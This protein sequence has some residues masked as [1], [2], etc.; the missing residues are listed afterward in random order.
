MN[1]VE[2]NRINV[3][4]IN[5]SNILNVCAVDI[6]DDLHLYGL[7]EEFKFDK[8]TKKVFYHHIIST[9]CNCIIESNSFNKSIIFYNESDIKSNQLCDMVTNQRM[10]S[11]ITN[12]LNKVNRLLPIRLFN[13]VDTFN[14][15]VQLLS[16]NSGERIELHAKLVDIVSKK[17]VSDFRNIKTFAK[18]YDLTFLSETFFNKIKT[19]NLMF[20]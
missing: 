11:F 15:T 2:I 1:G 7:Y 10:I 17:Q 6:L 19:K 8:D 12:T 3:H 18:R 5:F 4:L 9:L 20:L 16:T 13:S 14:D